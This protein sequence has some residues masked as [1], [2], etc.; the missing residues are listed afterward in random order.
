MTTE[1]KP[2]KPTILI[3]EDDENIQQ[4]VGYNLVKAGFQVIYA[5]NGEQALAL[6]QREAPDLVVLDVML[7]G[8][9]GYQICKTL[10]RDPRHRWLPIIMLTA[11]S[12]DDDVTAGLDQGADDYIT[13]PFSPK[14]LVS[15]VKSAL[16]RSREL[17]QDEDG[18]VLRL[19]EA[20]IV[21]DPRRHQ[22]LVQDKPVSL[23]I[24]EFS[25]LELLA[26]RPGWVFSRQ[27]IIDTVR[28]YDYAITPRAVDVQVFG[29]RKKLGQAGAC[30]ETVRGVGYRLKA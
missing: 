5:D 6:V 23:T 12:D 28:G 24:S 4:L 22:V 9:D 10:R 7:P 18:G 17:D 27:Q 2:G 8:M 26:R 20:G 19:T 14:I 25:I 16:R 30:I 29:L 15:R 11:R 21:I 3:V 1:S 13:K